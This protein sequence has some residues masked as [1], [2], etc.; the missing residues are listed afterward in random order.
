MVLEFL[1][2][3]GVLQGWVFIVLQGLLWR[4]WDEAHGID[5]MPFIIKDSPWTIFVGI[6]A[7]ASFFVLFLFVTYCLAMGI[8]T[9]YKAWGESIAA[10]LITPLFLWLYLGMIHLWR[11]GLQ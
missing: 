9:V 1:F 5:G 2:I 10:L 7:F 11:G 6:M 4:N 8:L 3:V